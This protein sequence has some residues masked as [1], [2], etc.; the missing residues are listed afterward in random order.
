[1]LILTL[2]RTRGTFLQ[3]YAC[4]F[5]G[6]WCGVFCTGRFFDSLYHLLA[7]CPF[8]FRWYLHGGFPRVNRRLHIFLCF[9]QQYRY[10]PIS[11]VLFTP[12]SDSGTPSFKAYSSIVLRNSRAVSIV[13]LERLNGGCPVCSSWRNFNHSF[14]SSGTY[15]DQSEISRIVAYIFL[16]C[17]EEI[18]L[19]SSIRSSPL[20]TFLSVM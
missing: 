5:G 11:S 16:R 4:L 6:L 8:P 3:S 7:F 18:C 19:P 9:K 13:Q 14:C 17:S 2:F 12:L 10:L 15:P 1:M 20:L